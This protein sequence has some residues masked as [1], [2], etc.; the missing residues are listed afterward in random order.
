MM[1]ASYGSLNLSILL[2]DYDADRK[3]NIADKVNID[4]KGDLLLGILDYFCMP[5]TPGL[6]VLSEMAVMNVRTMCTLDVR[7]V[8]GAE[9]WEDTMEEWCSTGCSVA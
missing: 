9:T 8:G 6:S 1:A 7:I 5:S 2:D 4:R 3:V